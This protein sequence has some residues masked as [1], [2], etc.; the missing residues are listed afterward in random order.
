MSEQPAPVPTTA[1]NVAWT[2]VLLL[3]AVAGWFM[4]RALHASPADERD[5]ECRHSCQAMRAEFVTATRYGCFCEEGEIP[6]I[7][8]E[9][10]YP[11]SDP[12]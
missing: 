4:F 11:M 2:A 1:S 3:L 9:A 12:E 8:D 6:F 10:R 7:L 5:N